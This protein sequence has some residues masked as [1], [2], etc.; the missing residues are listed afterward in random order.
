VA[1]IYTHGKHTI[2]TID[3]DPIIDANT[4]ELSTEA[5]EHDNTVYGDNDEVP[6]GGIL[7]GTFTAGGLYKAGATGTVDIIPPLLGTT[8]VA[9]VKPEGTGTGKPLLTFSVLIKKFVTTRPVAG[10]QTWSLEAKKSGALV[11]TTQT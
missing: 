1:A 11:K 10:Y 2:I 3:S 5:D 6:E 4:S 8:V 7:R 9:T